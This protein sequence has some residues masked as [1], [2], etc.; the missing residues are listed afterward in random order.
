MPIARYGS[1]SRCPHLPVSLI[2]FKRHWLWLIY[3][4]G[5]FKDALRRHYDFQLTSSRI[6]FSDAGSHVSKTCKS[7]L[8]AVKWSDTYRIYTLIPKRVN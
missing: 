2:F 4:Q 1:P 7:V 8:V 3:N 6:N 5:C